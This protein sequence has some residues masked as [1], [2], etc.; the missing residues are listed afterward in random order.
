MFIIPCLIAVTAL[1]PASSLHDAINSLCAL[2]PLRTLFQS[3]LTSITV[4]LGDAVRDFYYVWCL[5]IFLFD[6]MQPNHSP[7]LLTAFIFIDLQECEHFIVC[8][9]WQKIILA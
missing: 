9:S 3:S 1:K 7:A 5:F 8:I 4:V 2:W 6:Y